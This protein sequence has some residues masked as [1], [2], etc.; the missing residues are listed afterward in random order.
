MSTHPF[1]QVELINTARLDVFETVSLFYLSLAS[2]GV[3][4]GFHQAGRLPRYTNFSSE[5]IS[6]FVSTEAMQICF[7]SCAHDILSLDAWPVVHRCVL[8]ESF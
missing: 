2:L 7:R 1:M 5:L 4:E 8:I 6:G 3:L